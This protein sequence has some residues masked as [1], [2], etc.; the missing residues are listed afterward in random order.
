VAIVA[1]RPEPKPQPRPEPEPELEPIRTKIEL[2]NRVEFR[3]N[4]ARL[5]TSSH[6]VLDAVAE[7]LEKNQHIRLVEIGGHTDSRG[8]ARRNRKLSRRRAVTVRDY[9]FKRGVAP[10]RLVIKGYGESNPVDNNR[11]VAGRERNRRVEFTILERGSP[12]QGG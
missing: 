12:S 11:T 2:V 1:P 8:K 3:K 5:L 9:L 4:G 6:T 10:D 7:V